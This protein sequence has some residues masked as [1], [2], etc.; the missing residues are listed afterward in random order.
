M[1]VLPLTC[2]SSLISYLV[3]EPKS[4]RCDS[5]VFA[6][7]IAC[8][9]LGACQWRRGTLTA[10]TL[11]LYHLFF[12]TLCVGD[13]SELDYRVASMCCDIDVP[14]RA[15]RR[16]SSMQLF[17]LQKHPFVGIYICMLACAVDLMHLYIL[18]YLCVCK[19]SIVLRWLAKFLNYLCL[20]SSISCAQ[21]TFVL[22]LSKLGYLIPLSLKLFA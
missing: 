7:H 15:R 2:G 6:I 3:H 1:S 17:V 12:S 14:V 11:A 19:Q 10:S 4:F 16:M 18:A 20:I 13:S 5:I 22:F 21:L 9:A 8:F